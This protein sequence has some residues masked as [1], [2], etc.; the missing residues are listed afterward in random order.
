MLYLVKHL[1]Y[2]HYQQT[3]I[4]TCKVP[5][6]FVFDDGVSLLWSTIPDLWMHT[7]K[8]GESTWSKSLTLMFKRTGLRAHKSLQDHTFEFRFIDYVFIDNTLIRSSHISTLPTLSF[9]L[10]LVSSSVFQQK[11][12]NYCF[13]LITAHV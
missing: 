7:N 8:P 3:I 5:I 1:H 2:F 12:I 6:Q 9:S 13:V 11:S 10:T 4:L